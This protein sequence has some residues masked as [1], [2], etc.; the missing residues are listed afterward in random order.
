MN[1]LVM[2]P[3]TI[4]LRSPF[5][6]P[7]W[8]YP[9]NRIRRI[10]EQVQPTKV[11]DRILPNKP[12]NRR[13]IVPIPVVVQTRLMVVILALKADRVV[14]PHLFRPGRT[15]LFRLAP[16]LVLRRPR[17]VAV[18]VGQLHRRTQVVTLVPRNRIK[19]LWRGRLLPERVLIDV[20]GAVAPV[21]LLVQPYRGLAQSL[22]HR[23]KAA[24]FVQVVH[25][26]PG[27]TFILRRR[28]FPGEGV[29]VPAE[30][31]EAAVQLALALCSLKLVPAS[32]GFRFVPVMRRRVLVQPSPE[33]VIAVLD[34]ELELVVVLAVQ[35]IKQTLGKLC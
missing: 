34:L 17:H 26:A 9:V 5:S 29:A 3:F 30:Q 1:D 21:R 19:G 25:R 14:Q 18:V 12:P 32:T 35:P 23:H 11:T 10:Y 31:G 13:I 15:F 8:I 24:R 2:R 7:K 6:Q 20:V 28:A 33:G 27:V 4:G 22:R 16:R